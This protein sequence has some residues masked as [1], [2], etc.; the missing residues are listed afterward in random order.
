L[1]QRAAAPTESP[2][3]RSVEKIFRLEAVAPNQLGPLKEWYSMVLDSWGV[4]LQRDGHLPAAERRF[5]LA[6]ELNTNNW[7]ARINLYCNTNLQAGNKMSLADAA[8]FASQIGSVKKLGLL[9]SRLG[10]L[11][12]PGFCY[13]L[14][15]V[16]QESGLPRQA[17]QQFSRAYDL[18]PDALAP[19]FAL[20]KLAAQYRMPDLAMELINHIRDVAKSMPANADLDSQMALLEAGIWLS[21][22]NVNRA[23]GI[24]QNVVQQHPDDART[25]YRISQAYLAFGDYTNAGPLVTRLLDREPDNVS[26]LMMQSQILLQTARADLAIPVLNHV[27]SLTNIPDAKLTRAI[28]YVQIQNYT[29]ARADCLELDNSLTNC[30][31]AEYWLAQ[32][33]GLQHDTNQAVYYF[34]LCLTNAPP[35]TLL[36]REARARLHTFKPDPEGK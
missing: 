6:S 13:L 30:F 31:L 33:A 20:A 2:M 24:L 7:V 3:V 35:Q 28:A 34:Q 5:R 36:W 23:A 8:D 14:G 32:I 9:I 27:L 16:F 21:Q 29:A 4:E 26:V 10:P 15:Y 25:L 19:P 1:L 17:M 12:D 18:V 11:D 22:T